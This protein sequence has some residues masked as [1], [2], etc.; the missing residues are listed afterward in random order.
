M[1]LFLSRDAILNQPRSATASTQRNITTERAR[2]DLTSSFDIV[3]GTDL[4]IQQRFQIRTGQAK[5]LAL[6]VFIM[7]PQAR[8]PL[9][10][11]RGYF[12]QF[13]REPRKTL[14]AIALQTL[15]VIPLSQMRVCHELSDSQNRP[16]T[17]AGLLE[18][19]HGRN[20]ALRKGP[21]RDEGVQFVV[22]LG[23]GVWCRETRI[24]NQV[25]LS[26]DFTQT[27]PFSF[28][29]HHE[30]HPFVVTATLI[31]ALG[32]VPGISVANWERLG[33][34]HRIF[35]KM[36]TGDTDRR[37]LNLGQIDELALSCPLSIHQGGHDGACPH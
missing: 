20:V 25:R 5:Q 32:C 8:P 7:L 10:N 9:G 29:T 33:S 27:L 24:S 3:S 30:G 19:V 18:H 34:I 6:Y 22:V 23:P 21:L 35:Q 2:P 13:E 12:G 16:R 28:G 4:I 1:P 26:Y 14:G 15:K 37:R 11:F 36:F 31:T 17:K